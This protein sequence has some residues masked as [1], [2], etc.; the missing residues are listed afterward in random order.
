MSRRNHGAEGFTT[1]I[2]E[3]NGAHSLILG[4]EDIHDLESDGHNG[5]DTTCAYMATS[6]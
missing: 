2:E 1:E 3:I 5:E 4:V 6:D